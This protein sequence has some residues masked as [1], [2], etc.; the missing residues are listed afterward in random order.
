[1]KRSTSKPRA[2]RERATSTPGLEE[3]ATKTER[4]IAA[5]EALFRRNGVRGTTMEAIAAEAGVAKATAY[6]S[7]RNKDDAFRAVCKRFVA[8]LDARVKAAI[9]GESA[10]RIEAIL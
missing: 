9:E 6:A 5:A 10:S 7:F 2:T 3:V 1:M 4:L 8:Q